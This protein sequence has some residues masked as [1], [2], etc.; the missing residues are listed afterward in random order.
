MLTLRNATVCH[1]VIGDTGKSFM[2]THLYRKP[3]FFT[4]ELPKYSSV[5]AP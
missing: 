4:I 5:E 3:I 2:R 1:K